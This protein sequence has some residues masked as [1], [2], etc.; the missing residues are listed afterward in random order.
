M[1]THDSYE[2]I[3][4]YGKIH[5]ERCKIEKLYFVR[6]NF[7]LSELNFLQVQS[8]AMPLKQWK[9]VLL[10]IFSTSKQTARIIFCNKR[11]SFWCSNSA[12]WW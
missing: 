1:Y 10:V 11:E 4:I 3:I 12:R 6:F 9:N 2:R 8:K 7:S 5:K